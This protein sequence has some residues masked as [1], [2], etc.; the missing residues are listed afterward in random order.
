MS[1]YG[2]I[3]GRCFVITTRGRKRSIRLKVDE[4]ALGEIRLHWEQFAQS[5]EICIDPNWNPFCLPFVL[6]RL[7]KDDRQTDITQLA[8]VHVTIEYYFQPY[9]NKGGT[10]VN[11]KLLSLQRH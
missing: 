8:T 4:T 11:I 10:G 6:V 5:R 1:N 3:T 7:D 9:H 2:T